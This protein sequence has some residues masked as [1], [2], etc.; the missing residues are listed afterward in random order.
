[1]SQLATLNDDTLDAEDKAAINDLR[2][3]LYGENSIEQ[4]P[5]ELGDEWLRKSLGVPHHIWTDAQRYPAKVKGR[6]RAAQILRNQASTINRWHEILADN[7][8]RHLQTQERENNRKGKR[9]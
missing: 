4:M 8:K 6:L 1:M 7:L 9:T 3:K 2:R 5:P